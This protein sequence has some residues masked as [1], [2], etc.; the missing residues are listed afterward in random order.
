MFKGLG[1]EDPVNIQWKEFEIVRE[2][3]FWRDRDL[4]SLLPIGSEEFNTFRDQPITHLLDGCC[5]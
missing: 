1:L 4:L 5:A 3:D 2:L